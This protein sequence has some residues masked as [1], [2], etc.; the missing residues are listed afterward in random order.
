MNTIDLPAALSDRMTVSSSSVSCGVSTAVGSSR[1]SRST[2]RV[3][4][5]TI[6]T[7]CWMPTGRSSIT[8]SGSTRR[9]YR[10]ETSAT[11]RR[12][13]RR[14]RIPAKGPLTCSAPSITFSATVKTGTSMKCWCT[15]PIPAAIASDGPFSFSGLPST[16]ISPSSG[17]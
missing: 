15:I 7:R 12:A 3:R 6:S 9:L 8:A 10:S 17:W 4:A 2:S 13:R 14:S 1:I 16:R 11:S 5:L